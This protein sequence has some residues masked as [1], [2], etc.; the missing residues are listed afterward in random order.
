MKPSNKSPLLKHVLATTAVLAIGSAASLGIFIESGAYN[1]AADAPHTPLVFAL[2]ERM[3]E[4]SITSRASALKV[5]VLDDQRRIVHGA[6]NYN[7]MCV[8]CHRSPGVGA[9]ELSK[10][11]YPSPPNLSMASVDPTHAFWAIKHGIKGSGMPAWGSDMNDDDIWNMTAFLQVLPKLDQAH[12]QRLVAQ[13]G[14]H[15][16]GGVEAHASGDADVHQAGE[17]DH[18]HHHHDSAEAPDADAHADG[19]SPRHGTIH[20]HLHT[21]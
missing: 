17:D 4:R 3:R 21:Q 9:S 14:G 15:S 13:S 1:F 16:H 8:Q 2:L 19:K 11:L 6:G 7:A 12:Y 10:G 5:P 18:H 20:T